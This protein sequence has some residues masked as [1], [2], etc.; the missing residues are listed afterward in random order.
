MAPFIY[1]PEGEPVAKLLWD[2]IL[3]EMSFAKV[4]DILP[5]INEWQPVNRPHIVQGVPRQMERQYSEVNAVCKSQ[6]QNC[7][8]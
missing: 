4:E 2:E 6:G 1:E 8:Y 5:Q 3:E 7:M